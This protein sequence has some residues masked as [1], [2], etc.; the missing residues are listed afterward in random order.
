MS[1]T[2]DRIE[3]LLPDPRPRPA[4][5]RAAV[6]VVL[7]EWEG[8]VEVL[9]M[10]RAQRDGDPWSG[11]ISC[12]GGFEEAHDAG[13]VEAA[14]RETQEELGLDLSGARVLGGLP[15][16][17]A[18]PWSWMS[19]F[20]VTPVVFAIEGDPALTL[21]ATEVVSVR[22]VPLAR[23]EDRA[24]HEGF[25]FFW[26]PQ[27]RWPLPVPVRVWRVRDGDFEIWGLTYNVLRSLCAQL[28]RDPV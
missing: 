16:R 19:S 20:A 25:W 12:P 3:A 10:R 22:W 27:K 11:D 28:P 24:R 15:D 17:P 23:V 21:D 18:V 6:A 7:R 5:H 1:A 14:R 9:L 2:F 26:R 13:P 4:R 8:R